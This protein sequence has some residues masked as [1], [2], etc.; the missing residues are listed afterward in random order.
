MTPKE[1]QSARNAEAAAGAAAVPETAVAE[2][3]G[4][5]ESQASDQIQKLLAEKQELMNT[6]I[7]RQ[8]DYENYR[9][10]VEK[11]KHHER[12]RGL[13]QLLESLL[14]V[15]DAFD[16]ALA[17]NSRGASPEYLK[18]FELTRRQLWD[19]LSKE[20]IQRIE[21]VGKEFNPHLHHALERVETTE[22]AEGTVVAELQPGYV[23]H[24]RVL[25]PAMVRVAAAPEREN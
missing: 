3:P 2:S 19:V 12:R 10:R 8:A 13:E 16:L 17:S 24:D 9:K 6:L 5:A 15:L 4:A 25:R 11:E 7:R 23:Y 20:G 18:G 21:A 1:N 14:P 22:H